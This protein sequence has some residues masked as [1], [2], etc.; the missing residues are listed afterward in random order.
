MFGLYASPGM[1]GGVERRVLAFGPASEGGDELLLESQRDFMEVKVFRS[2]GRKRVVPE[3]KEFQGPGV[4]S[5]GVS[6]K[7]APAYAGDGVE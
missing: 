5:P 7:M 4:P 2:K 3:A 6:K 1:R